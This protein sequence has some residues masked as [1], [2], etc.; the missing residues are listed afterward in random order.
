MGFLIPLFQRLLIW[1]VTKILLALGLSF[2][3]YTGITLSL[4]SLK[5]YVA[6]SINNIPAD[7]FSLLMMAG[8]GQA[9]GIIFGAFAF[10]VAM[11]SATKLTAGIMKKI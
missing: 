5:N 7:V 8:F 2:V 3:T 4:N 11:E 9:V 6:T 1:I 10:K